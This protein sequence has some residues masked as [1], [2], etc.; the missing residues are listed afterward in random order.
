MF[1]VQLW[2][3]LLS[4]ATEKI[5]S[6]RLRQESN[7]VSNIL[8]VQRSTFTRFLQLQSIKSREYGRIRVSEN[9][10]SGKFYAMTTTCDTIGLRSSY[11][12]QTNSVSIR[13]NESHT[14]VL[15]GCAMR[16]FVVNMLLQMQKFKYYEYTNEKISVLIEG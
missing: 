16:Y 6:L 11:L 12:Q 5:C 7:S 9:P 14:E 4:G 2:S 13:E 3:E 8:I 1:T 10:C 15:K